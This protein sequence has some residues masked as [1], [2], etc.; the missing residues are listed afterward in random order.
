MS[1]LFIAQLYGIP[2]DARQQISLVILMLFTAKG[3][4]GVTGGAFAS[5]AATVIASGLPVE[6]LALLL[7][8]DRFMSL[9][10]ALVNVIGNSVAAIVVAKW[11]GGFDAI[12]WNATRSLAP[13]PAIASPV[14]AAPA[15]HIVT[16]IAER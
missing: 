3:A 10:R 13:A 6:G 11:D 4:A 15:T 12:T 7:G 5:L 2:L 9:G 1:V 16:Q 8:V 14:H